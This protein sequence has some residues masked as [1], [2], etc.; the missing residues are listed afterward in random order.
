MPK[1]KKRVEKG[2]PAWLL[3]HCVGI[4]TTYNRLRETP[5]TCCE[6]YFEQNSIK[7]SAHQE[8]IRQVFYGIERF[9]GMIKL[10]VAGLYGNNP[11]PLPIISSPIHIYSF[12]LSQYLLLNICLPLLLLC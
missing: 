10:V 3:D 5:F 1:A 6:T 4:I 11:L 2:S 7:D 8:F 9:S 12:F